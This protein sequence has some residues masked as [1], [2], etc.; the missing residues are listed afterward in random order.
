[1]KILVGVLY[2]LFPELVL[3][4]AAALLSHRGTEFS[5]AAA[6][7]MQLAALCILLAA[8]ALSVQ[9]NR[10]RTFFASLTTLL[11]YGALVTLPGPHDPIRND[12]L[13]G[14]VCLFLPLNLLAAHALAERG[15][16]TR[17]AAGPFIALG[18]EILLAV[19]LV[20][21]HSQG[22]ADALFVQF[23]RWPALAATGISQPGMLVLALGLLWLNDRLIRR[24]SPELAAFFL[25]LVAAA[26]MLHTRAPVTLAVFAVVI[27]LAF[28]LALMRESWNMAYTD[29]LTD[30]PGR[31]ALEEHL[32]RLGGR[33]TIAMLDIDHFKSFNDSY[34]HDAGDQVLRLV[35]TRL[36]QCAGSGKPFRY[37]GEE[38]SLSFPGKSLEE[39][40]PALEALRSEIETSG[41]NLRRGE[42]R[43]L[44]DSRVD[45]A[46]E[47]TLQVTVSI[48][49][50]QSSAKLADPWAVLH[51]A[52]RALYKAKQAG[53]NRVA[54]AAG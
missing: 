31:R 25:A 34:G 17:Y 38:F 35:A 19:A 18:V 21:G 11:A 24:H 29:E 10:R 3:L 23:I 8:L 1:M 47:V 20:A 40:T 50:A 45:A 13:L 15:I 27:G 16:F 53:R 28:G 9:F 7:A 4:I 54:L 37:G 52:D 51:T 14:A 46:D 32:R 49:A 22:I 48:G 41:F 39:I 44:G 2:T 12:T 42:R 6:L 33:Y 26:V 5:P 36:Q 43:S 30:L